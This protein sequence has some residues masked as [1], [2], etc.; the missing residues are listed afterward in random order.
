MVQLDVQ[1]VAH[2]FVQIGLGVV[3][4]VVVLVIHRRLQQLIQLGCVADKQAGVEI[5]GQVLGNRR[6]E[7][8]QRFVGPHELLGAEHNASVEFLEFVHD[9]IEVCGEKDVITED[10]TNCWAISNGLKHTY[11]GYFLYN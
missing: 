8:L 7:M 9:H 2:V 6:I 5:F 10:K 3:Q 1:L 11:S 4:L